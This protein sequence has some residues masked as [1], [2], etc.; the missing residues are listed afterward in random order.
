MS[1][2]V[3]SRSYRRVPLLLAAVVAA[4]GVLAGSLAPQPAQA[5]TAVTRVGGADRWETAILLSKRT[6][7]SHSDIVWLAS[8]ENYPDALAAAPAA[9]KQNATLLLTAKNSLPPAVR[10]E[11]RRLAPKRI[12]VA[13]GTAA[14]SAAVVSQ[15]QAATGAAV[16]RYAGADRYETSTKI[17]AGVWGK[18]SIAGGTVWVANGADYPGALAAAAAAGTSLWHANKSPAPLILVPAT[19]NVGRQKTAIA[20]TGAATVRIA[21]GTKVVSEQVRAALGKNAVRYAGAD[22]YDT[23]AK[24]AA[25]LPVGA[26]ATNSQSNV[27]L[28]SGENFPDALV[29]ARL[30]GVKNQRLYLS[31]KAAL[32][33]STAA[34]LKARPTKAVTIIGG[35]QALS[36]SVASS[37]ANAAALAPA[38]Q[39]PAQ[40]KP[41]APFLSEGAN[42]AVFYSPHQDDETLF[43]SQAIENAIARL[44]ADNVYVVLMTDGASTSAYAPLAPFID[45]KSKTSLYS[46]LNDA[47]AYNYTEEAVRKALLRVVR[48]GEFIAAAGAL[49]IPQNNVLRLGD[50]IP[51]SVGRLKDGSLNTAQAQAAIQSIDQ[52]KRIRAGAGDKIAHFAFSHTYDNHRDHLALGTALSGAKLGAG[53]KYFIVRSDIAQPQTTGTLVLTALPNPANVLAASAVYT[54]SLKS[55]AELA[56]VNNAI[57]PAVA[58]RTEKLRLSGMSA[59]DALV[60]ALEE[61]ADSLTKPG[62]ANKSVPDLF[63]TLEKN[64]KAATLRTTLHR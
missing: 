60:T 63:L 23:A 22:R 45:T 40:A 29:G 12:V 25:S 52:S 46:K 9:V 1:Q 42:K 57:A 19:G 54:R 16:T 55:A 43:Y 4:V 2:H 62:I 7:A 53:V 41:V 38:P 32:P 36:P 5:A 26:N 3:A 15:A 35:P 31:A 14:V 39:P 18:N 64:V 50:E 49:G 20:G 10:N 24:I 51:G 28:A 27:Y 59:Q 58:A 47:S 61:Q 44:G 33:A 21:G 30:A 6:H 8:G 56:K 13:G 11:L 34:A 37:A 17:A 48:D